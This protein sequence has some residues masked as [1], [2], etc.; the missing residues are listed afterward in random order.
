MA[1]TPDRSL[2]IEVQIFTFVFLM[3]FCNCLLMQ[4]V[5]VFLNGLVSLATNDGW[6]N[7]KKANEFCPFARFVIC[8][9]LVSLV[10]DFLKRKTFLSKESEN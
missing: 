1:I 5:Q 10:L 8:Q 4:K 9:P 3:I 6:A 2:T 7:E